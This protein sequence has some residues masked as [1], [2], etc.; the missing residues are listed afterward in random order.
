MELES[1]GWFLEREAELRLPAWV[2]VLSFTRVPLTSARHL[3]Y[4]RELLADLKPIRRIA[5]VIFL[6]RIHLRLV[7]LQGEYAG[8]RI[9]DDSSSCSTFVCRRVDYW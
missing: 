8:G 9:E 7:P 6:G 5:G 2:P 1:E 3:Y 4:L